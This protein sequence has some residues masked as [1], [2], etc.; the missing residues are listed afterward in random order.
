MTSQL[1]LHSADGKSIYTAHWL[2]AQSPIAVLVIAHGLGEHCGRYQPFIQYFVQR[3]YAVYALD[4]EGHGK[5]EGKRGYISHFT[6]Y[7]E[8]LNNYVTTIKQQHPGLPVFLV[9]HSMGGV[10]S[11]NYLIKYQN[12]LAGCILSGPA[13]ATDDVISPF[14]KK[15]LKVLSFTT[16]KLPLIKIEGA[17]VS[18]DP[19]VVKDYETDPLV[20]RGKVTARLLT[21]IISSAENALREAEKIKLPLLIL[22]GDSDMLAHPKGSQQL[23]ATVGS[24]DK[25]L[26]IYPELYHEIFLEPEKNAVFGDIEIWLNRQLAMTP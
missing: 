7:V 13:L 25:T 5:S 12:K 8:T 11:V 19:D 18:R 3:G 14:Q 23:A 16:P 15:L 10:I 22:H 17:A 9:G 6:D 20:F 24:K 26:K 4:H 1:S 2:S 21:E